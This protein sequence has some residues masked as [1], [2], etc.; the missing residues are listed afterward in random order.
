MSVVGA[1][2]WSYCW[3]AEIGREGGH[4]GRM[5]WRYIGGRVGGG[6]LRGL[7]VEGRWESGLVQSHAIGVAV[8]S[9]TTEMF[10]DSEFPCASVLRQGAFLQTLARGSGFPSNPC[11][12]LVGP[13]HISCW[14]LVFF[15]FLLDLS[16]HS[17][18]DPV[19]S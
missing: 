19:L 17:S 13:L 5:D 2:V 12:F 3:H 18:L 7:T 1:V 9:R 8:K 14:I 4:G 6:G 15:F 10:D 16:N 11:G